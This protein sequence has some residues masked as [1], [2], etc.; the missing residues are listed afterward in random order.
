MS[1]GN[2]R[3]ILLA[4]E[5]PV[6]RY[7]RHALIVGVAA[8][9]A[10]A[11]GAL[12]WPQDFF[13]SYLI[14]FLLW[15]GV[16]L[17]SLALLMIHHI[18]GGAWGAVIRRVLESATR[19]LPFMAALF[20]PVLLGM[21]QLY[22]WSHA[23]TVA[24][25]VILQHKSVYL[26]VPF[27]LARAAV[28]FA[29]WSLVVYY[30]NRWSLEQDS[31]GG[32]AVAL[33]MEQLSRGGLVLIGL[34]MS[35]AAV[36]WMMSIE[37]HWFSTIYGMLVIGGQVVSA[38]AFAIPVVALLSTAGAPLAGAVK[39]DHLHDL[40]KLL[41][42]FVMVWTYFHLSQFLIIWSAN[43]PEEIPWYLKRTRGGW[44]H[45]AMAIVLLHFLLPFALLLSRDVKRNPRMLASIA[46]VIIAA[47]LLDLFWMV[48]PAFSPGH[49]AVHWMDLLAP[50]GVGG[51][52]YW[53][54]VRQLRG[55]SL[56]AVHDP[57]L[58]GGA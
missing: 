21:H 35:F 30:M 7:Q 28:Y 37:P 25:D 5:H 50:V 29:A 33:R 54:F 49:F 17:G 9:A 24:R 55:R 36:D 6:A 44:Q 14:A 43:L 52:W 51:V 41:F 38:M 39:R 10:C 26:N 18:T 34:T 15:F 16:G 46:A 13:R 32:P 58:H 11:A 45:V 47:R 1:Q 27:F 8:L 2:R 19:T 53:I 3:P 22:E 12:R 57:S 31:D 23:E 4:A 20:V 40:G 56:L 48:T 42:A